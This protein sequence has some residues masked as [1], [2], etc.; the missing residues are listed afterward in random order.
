MKLSLEFQPIQIQS[1]GVDVTSDDFCNWLKGFLE[2]AKPDKV[3]YYEIDPSYGNK[4]TQ[5]GLNKIH[6]LEEQ[7]IKT[8]EDLAKRKIRC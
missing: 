8:L 7:R 4:E 3:F 6:N 5:D 2:I 1:T